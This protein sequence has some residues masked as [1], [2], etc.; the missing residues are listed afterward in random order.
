[1]AIP[2]PTYPEW[3]LTLVWRADEDGNGT[4]TYLSRAEPDKEP[5]ELQASFHPVLNLLEA[6]DSALTEFFESTH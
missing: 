5:E 1:M 3:R 2:P 4:R 6:V